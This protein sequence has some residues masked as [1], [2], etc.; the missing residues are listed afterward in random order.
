MAQK[1]FLRTL[2]MEEEKRPTAR[3]SKTFHYQFNMVAKRKISAGNIVQRSNFY[4][5][6]INVPLI[7]RQT[8]RTRFRGLTRLD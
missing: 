2:Q 1:R 7:Y 5:E 4:C 8:G 3:A 6:V